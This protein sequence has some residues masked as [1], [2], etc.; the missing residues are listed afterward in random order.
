MTIPLDSQPNSERCPACEHAKK[1]HEP[2]IGCHLCSCTR[3]GL[4]ATAYLTPDPNSRSGVSFAKGNP[5][6][7]RNAH[8]PASIRRIMKKIALEKEARIERLIHRLLFESG[9]VVASQVLKLVNEQIDGRA[10]QSIRVT[11]AGDGPVE[12]IDYSK[13]PPEKLRALRAIMREAMAAE[14]D[15]KS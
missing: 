7:P 4:D 5:G 9:D 12:T 14:D 2:S 6:R 8:G 1:D 10:A 15:N 11:G 3:A 13:I